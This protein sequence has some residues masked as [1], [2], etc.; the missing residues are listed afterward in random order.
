[1][2]KKNN[3]YTYVKIWLIFAPYKSRQTVYSVNEVKPLWNKVKGKVIINL[4]RNGLCMVEIFLKVY[5]SFLSSITCICLF[6][7]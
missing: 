5:G 7:I 2:N 3:L 1:M 6:Q 4:I